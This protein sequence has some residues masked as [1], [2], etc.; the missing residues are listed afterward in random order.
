MSLL[1]PVIFHQKLAAHLETETA[2][3]LKLKEKLKLKLNMAISMTVKGVIR[4][5]DEDFNHNK[6]FYE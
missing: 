1:A 4:E 6:I 3:D 5:C 2:G